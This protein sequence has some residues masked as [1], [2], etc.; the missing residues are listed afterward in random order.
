MFVDDIRWYGNYTV[1]M[2]KNLGQ[3]NLQLLFHKTQPFSLISLN[4]KVCYLMLLFTLWNAK[5]KP[6]WS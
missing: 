6:L 4:I 2:R 5:A 1:R 3:L